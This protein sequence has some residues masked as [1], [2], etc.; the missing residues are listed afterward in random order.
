MLKNLL[1]NAFKFTDQGGVRLT[2]TAA[3]GGWSSEHPVLSQSP[4]VV[5][6]EVSDTG[7]GIPL[8]KQKIIFEAFQQAD[9]SH[10]PQIRR[11][12]PR[13]RHQPRAGQPARRRNPAAQHAR[14][15]L[16]L[17]ALSAGE[18]R[19]P[20]QRGRRP[21][22]TTRTPAMHSPAALA[23]ASPDRPIEQIPDDRLEIQPGD[24]I[25]LIVED[26]PHY[27]RIILDLAR[28][29]GF[30]VLVATRGATRSILPS[31]SSR[32]RSRST[33]SCPTCWAGRC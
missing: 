18:V 27:A 28:D 30:K 21:E 6:F 10:Q 5:A 31:S 3:V 7:I 9:A 20:D 22:R 19:R 4:G 2:A 16:D 23:V 11:H 29:K 25:L 12:R 1:S 24:T 17:H 32:P 26:D 14:Q 33:C 8:E 15:G 13:P